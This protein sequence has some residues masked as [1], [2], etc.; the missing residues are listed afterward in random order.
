MANRPT[1]A[2]MR[3]TEKKMGSRHQQGLLRPVPQA[4]PPIPASSSDE[5][6]VEAIESQGK[7]QG[8]PSP[9]DTAIVKQKEWRA[10]EAGP[11]KIK[12]EIQEVCLRP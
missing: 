5:E 4:P 1:V 8:C 11:T 10:N 9:R 12:R 6:S 3:S 2:T 7:S